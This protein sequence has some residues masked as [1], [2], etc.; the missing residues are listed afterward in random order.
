MSVNY[1]FPQKKNPEHSA[2]IVD[3]NDTIMIVTYFDL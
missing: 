2:L 1:T 3:K